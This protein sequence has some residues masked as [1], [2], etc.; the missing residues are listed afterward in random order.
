MKKQPESSNIEDIISTTKHHTRNAFSR[1]HSGLKKTGYLLVDITEIL[2]KSYAEP[3]IRFKFLD[4]EYRHKRKEH[5][6]SVEKRFIEKEYNERVAKFLSHISPMPIAEQSK[7]TF[8]Y[9]L[10]AF[11]AGGYQEWVMDAFSHAFHL[12][13]KKMIKGSIYGEYFNNPIS[14]LQVFGALKAGTFLEDWMGKW[15]ADYV[16]KFLEN[17]DNEQV[18]L[19]TCASG[20]LRYA[21]TYGR[22]KIFE[23]SGRYTTSPMRY[24][25][26]STF[27][28]SMLATGMTLFS[29]IK[30]QNRSQRISKSTHHLNM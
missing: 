11:I 21:F 27:Y 25:T 17:L 22:Q 18:L 2:Y 6:V 30:N 1:T 9:F 14:T 7:D 20:L 12:D 13:K 10:G 29:K 16:P 26:P 28:P 19:L 4:A 23:N 24:I 5:R 3:I 8:A 15:V